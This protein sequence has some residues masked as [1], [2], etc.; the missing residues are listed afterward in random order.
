MDNIDKSTFCL[1]E[2]ELS[3][4]KSKETDFLIESDTT[5]I[6]D[7]EDNKEETKEETKVEK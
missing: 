6:K 1:E 7:E 3:T 4:T 5:V 2:D